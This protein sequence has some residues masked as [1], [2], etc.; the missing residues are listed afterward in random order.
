MD[1]NP[2]FTVRFTNER[3]MWQYKLHPPHLISVARLPCGSQS[4]ENGNITAG[5]YQRK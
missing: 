1:F 2:V 5:H 3:H 4:T